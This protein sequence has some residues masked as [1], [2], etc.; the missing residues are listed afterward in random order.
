MSSRQPKVGDIVRIKK[1]PDTPLGVISHILTLTQID[2]IDAPGEFY[3]LGSQSSWGI[4]Y[5]AEELEVIAQEDV[6][7]LFSNK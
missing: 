7:K 5:R 3:A 4:L 2:D 1:F 6:P